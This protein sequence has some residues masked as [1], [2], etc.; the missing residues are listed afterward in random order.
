MVPG[1]VQL[2]DAVVPGWVQLTDAVV[3]GWVGELM[4]RPA[5][6]WSAGH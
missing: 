4:C 2:T 5:I 3:P 1:W 6:C